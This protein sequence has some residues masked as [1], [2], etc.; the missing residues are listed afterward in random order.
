MRRGRGATVREAFAR[1]LVRHLNPRYAWL[2][3]GPSRRPV[4]VL[5]AGCGPDD[6]VIAQRFFPRCV[7]EGVN[8]VDL[9][10]G[11][12]RQAFDRYHVVD[13]DETD[14]G[15]VPDGAFDYVVCSHTLEHLR[16]GPRV[17]RALGRK[18]AP[19]GLLYLEWPSPSARR[20]PL[21]GFGLNFEDDPTHRTAWTVDDVLG[22]IAPLGFEVAYAGRRR[23]KV[24]MA[25]APLLAVWHSFRAKR[26]VL[27]DFWDATGFCLVVRARRSEEAPALPS[28]PNR[29]PS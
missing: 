20:F 11:R 26:V 25:L 13:L 10:D 2:P 21:R 15:F 22:A 28:V 14:L 24:R 1:L 6:G 5:D 23:M 16:N 29:L 8:I 12:Q 19:G 7:V 18:V 9:R 17:A 4:R 27:Y 3:A